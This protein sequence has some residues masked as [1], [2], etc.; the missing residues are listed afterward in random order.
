MTPEEL[1]TLHPRLYHITINSWED[2]KQ[3]GLLST[4]ALLDLYQVPDD[5][6]QRLRT[7]IRPLGIT[8]QHNSLP[9]I[10]LN[11]NTPLKASIL[12]KKLEDSLTIADW[13]EILNERVFFWPDEELMENHLQAFLRALK[14]DKLGEGKR[15]ID[16]L[17][18]DTLS[19]AKAYADK[20]QF[21]AINSGTAIRNAAT[22]GLSTF[23]PMLDHDYKTWR[24]LRGKKDTIKEVTVLN[25]ICNIEQYVIEVRKY[26]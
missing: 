21:C 20:I 24:G 17:V 4:T 7:M 25:S 5:E 15:E 2:V 22:R 19:L 16:V 23:T 1:A 9:T 14:E 8:L 26:P 13:M 11:D 6:K 10:T 3:H 18:I 12:S